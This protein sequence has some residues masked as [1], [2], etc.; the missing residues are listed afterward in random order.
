MAKKKKKSR[1][2]RT[3]AQKAAF[4]KMRAGLAK[5]HG[6]KR[7]KKKGSKKRGKKRSKK[8]ASKTHILSGKY[9]LV[10]TLHKA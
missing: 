3:A 10:G 4:E 9:K 6:K 2:H 8:S 7:G 1:K 5:F